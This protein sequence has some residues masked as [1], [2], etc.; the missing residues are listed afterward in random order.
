M[1]AITNGRMVQ[2]DVNVLVS[3][4]AIVV[5]RI[6]VRIRVEVVNGASPRRLIDRAINVHVLNIDA[7]P[8]LVTLFLVNCF[9]A[10]RVWLYNRKI[11][12]IVHVD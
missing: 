1:D 9:H 2:M 6:V 5:N 11:A 10:N 12:I 3:I 4:A 7:R 8:I